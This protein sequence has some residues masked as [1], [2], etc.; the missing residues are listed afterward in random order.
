MVMATEVMTEE[1]WM[2]AVRTAP[3]RTSSSGFLI[4]A[5]NVLTASSS[6]KLSIELLIMERPTNSI[7]KPARM[8]PIF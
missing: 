8:P 1:L 5:R 7:P 3:T 2:I 4:D 6:A